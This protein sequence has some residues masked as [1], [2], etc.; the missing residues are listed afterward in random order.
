M[1]VL[2]VPNYG[3]VKGMYICRLLLFVL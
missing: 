2:V 3:V 1:E